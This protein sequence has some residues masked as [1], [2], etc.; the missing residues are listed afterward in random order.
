[1]EISEYTEQKTQFL[2]AEDLENTGVLWKI[3][4]EGEMLVD[5]FGNTK[6]HIP[7]ECKDEQKLF[8]CNKTNARTIQEA[9]DTETKKWIGRELKI[10]TYISKIDGQLRDIL[11]IDEVVLK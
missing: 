9:L 6:L 4:G 2:K 3:T 8:S 5:G 11:N 1:M 10:G 7:V